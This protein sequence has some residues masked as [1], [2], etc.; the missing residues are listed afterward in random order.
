MDQIMRGLVHPGAALKAELDKRGWNQSDLTFVLGCNPKAVNQIINAKQG[1]S[2]AMSKAL[3]D[4][5][6]L[7]AN[8]FA[9]LQQAHDL[10][11]AND[12]DPSISM[13]A[14]LSQ[15][16]PIREM[17]RRDWLKD[18]GADSLAE[19]L[20]RYFEVRS[21]HDVPY[22][23]HAAKKTVYEEREIPGPQLAW[24]F[25]VRQIAKSVAAPQYSEGK[26]RT[27]LE[28]MRRLRI[29]PEEARRV[30]RLLAECGL[31]LIIVEA[32]PGSAIDGVC[33]WLANSCPVIGLSM[34]FDRMDNFWFVLRH[35]IEHVLRGHGRSKREGMI[36]ADLHGDQ[37]G[38]GDSVP[39]EER[40]ANAAASNF[41]VPVEKM[42]SFFLR[43]HPFF[44]E[45]DVLAFAKIQSI[46]PSLPIG[47]IQHRLARYDYLKKHQAKIREFVL[48]GAIV[49]GWGQA[50]P[51]ER[52]G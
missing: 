40:V 16:Y 9:D 10:A 32:L 46:H 30:P 24:L 7:P 15:N 47:Q 3:G 31:R 4:A 20:A 48:P 13:R 39:E 17:I 38:T 14:R 5:L 45:K 11:S 23:A 37:A 36:D 43:K 21:P 12:P 28:T 8:F 18:G 34:R 6:N 33:L 26:L 19:Q 41:C 44:Y 52:V 50:M 29:A 22:L 49:D 1:V 25:R 2:P 35:E 27:A 42:K 51:L